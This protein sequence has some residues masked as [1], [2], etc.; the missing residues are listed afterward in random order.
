[1]RIAALAVLAALALA[2]PAQAA[3][4]TSPGVRLIAG[5]PERGV[6]SARAVGRHLYVSSL[7]GVSVFD[8]SQPQAPVRVGRLDLP[9]AQNEDV[10][11]GSGILL[12]SDDPYGGRGVLHVIDIRDPRHPRELSTYTTWVPGIFTGTPRRGGIGHTATCIQRCRYAW[13]AGSPAGIEVVDL[14]DPA[15]PRRAGRFAAR[16]AAGLFGTQDVQVDSS[17]LAWI[18]GSNG[19]AAYDPSRDP[20]H[21][22]L[23]MRTNARG[24]HGPL[25]DFIHHNSLRL[26]RRVVAITEEDFRDQCKRAGT[27][28]TWRIARRGRLRPLDSFGVER[29]GD[30]RVACS[31]HY[32]D[33][34]AGLIAQGFYEQGVRLIDARRPRRLRQVGYYLSRPGLFWGALFAPTDR[35]GST[36]Y[37]IDHSRGID[38]LAID[39]GALEPI[40][41]RGAR[42]PLKRP[43]FGFA[44]GVFGAPDQVRRGRRLSLRLDVAGRGGPVQVQATLSPSLVD[45]QVPR[46]ATWDPLARTLRY[47][48]ARVRGDA[49]RRL[50]ARVAPSAALGTPVEI[51]GYATGPDDPM[52]LDDRGVYRAVVARRGARAARAAAARSP[53]RGFCLLPYDYT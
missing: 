16:P 21:P 36:V 37:A 25:N 41:R 47:T 53:V 15:H 50:R 27:L 12:V 9:N 32:F 31:A 29:D 39:R 51:V 38:V 5:I 4:E 10:D 3:P 42:R 18:A 34:R 30:V 40:R 24:A 20:V 35:T 6:V 33:A 26:S 52:P 7:T 8:I 46:G 44:M 28:Q 48:L 43:K 49:A 14:R 1:M 11:V 17:G 2:T 23:V 22:R 13:L 45:V 19:T